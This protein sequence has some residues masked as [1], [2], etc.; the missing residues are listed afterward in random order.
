MPDIESYLSQSSKLAD[1]C[2]QNG[3]I[4]NDTLKVRVLGQTD[5]HITAMVTFEE[6]LM[7]S[8]GCVAGRKA[9][10]G[11]VSLHIGDEG[12]IERMEII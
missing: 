4:D 7:E 3:W 11:T 8:A 9:C 10:F 5:N 1:L 12:A 2:S 6:I